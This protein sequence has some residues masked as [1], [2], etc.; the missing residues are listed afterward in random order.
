MKLA[1]AVAIVFVTIAPAWAKKKKKIVVVIPRECIKGYVIMPDQCKTWGPYIRCDG[2]LIDPK[3]D[4]IC[5]KVKVVE[6]LPEIDPHGKL[7]GSGSSNAK[8]E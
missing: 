4:V 3:K 7:T 1:V 5:S 2:V 6:E 8:A